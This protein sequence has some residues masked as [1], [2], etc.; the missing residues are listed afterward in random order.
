MHAGRQWRPSACRFCRMAALVTP[1]SCETSLQPPAI[2]KRLHRPHN[3]RAHGSRAGLEAFL[4]RPHITVEVS[5]KQLIEPGTFGMPRPVSRRS[6]RKDAASWV[7]DQTEAGLGRIGP[8]TDRLLAE[9]HGGQQTSRGLRA[10][11]DL[12]A[13]TRFEPGFGE[14]VAGTNATR[15]L[16]D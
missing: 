14:D 8:R 13:A 11:V 15:K 16:H 9:G 3:H 1:N 2:K 12:T 6:L 4:V 7:L 5:F 10:A